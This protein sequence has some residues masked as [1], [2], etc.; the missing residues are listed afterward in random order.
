[1]I[2]GSSQALP[3]WPQLSTVLEIPL[4]HPRANQILMP[5][6]ECCEEPVESKEEE[7]QGS[8][9]GQCYFFVKIEEA[10]GLSDRIA[11]SEEVHE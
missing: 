3:D 4:K 1:M 11:V 5:A 10:T 9:M 6:D 8:G 7:G 2:P